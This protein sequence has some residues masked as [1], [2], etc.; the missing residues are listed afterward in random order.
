MLVVSRIMH[1]YTSPF[2]LLLALL[3]P[4]NFQSPP[5]TLTSIYRPETWW[6]KMMSSYFCRWPCW[7]QITRSQISLQHE[8]R[9]LCVTSVWHLQRDGVL[10]TSAAHER[11]MLR[12]GKRDGSESDEARCPHGLDSQNDTRWELLSVPLEPSP[13][14]WTPIAGFVLAVGRWR[15]Q[16]RTYITFHIFRYWRAADSLYEPSHRSGWRICRK[17]WRGSWCSKAK[18]WWHV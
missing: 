2:L 5:S 18:C 15:L 12:W 6:L 17:Q 11:G 10:R 4:P 8:V 3:P 14:F 13:G 9:E 16:A 7:R 1:T